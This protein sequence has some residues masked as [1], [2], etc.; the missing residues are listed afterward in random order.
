MAGVDIDAATEAGVIVARIPGVASGNA[1]SCAEMAIYLILALLR[2][3]VGC[4]NA[5][6]PVLGV[7]DRYLVTVS[8]VRAMLRAMWV[9]AIACFR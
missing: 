3:Q 8:R 9:R 5:T 4:V 7:A 6:Q 1:P 2:N